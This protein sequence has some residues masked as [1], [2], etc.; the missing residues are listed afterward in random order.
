MAVSSKKGS[1]RSA[2][3]R[4]GKIKAYYEFTYPER[5]LRRMVHDNVSVSGLKRWA[6]A[7]HTPSGTS[8]NGALVKIGK[9][10]KL[11]LH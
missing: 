5:K 11:N 6:D 1:P 3:K 4:S 9:I 8:G 7:Y 2:G 10:F